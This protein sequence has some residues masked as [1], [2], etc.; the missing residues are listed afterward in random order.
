M[1]IDLATVKD[2]VVIVGL[3]IA[4][5]SATLALLQYRRTVTWNKLNATFTLFPNKAYSDATTAVAAELARF[6]IDF[7]NLFVPLTEQQVDRIL[8]D[9]AAYGAVKA[10]INY[11]EDYATALHTGVLH[12]RIAFHLMGAALTRYFT[13]F[14]PLVEA[15]R[16]SSGQKRI[17]VEFEMGNIVFNRLLKL[18]P[19][20]E[21]RIR[22]LHEITAKE[23]YA[24]IGEDERIDTFIAVHD[25]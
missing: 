23:V 15:R 25:T 17:W 5:C 4:A 19:V 9:S 11:L 10:L 21:R 24:S 13:V 18:G 16:V 6:G 22:E 14:Q 12:R 1:N 7:H 3:P 20:D 8:G 2:L